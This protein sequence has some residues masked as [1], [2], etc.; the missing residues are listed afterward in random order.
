MNLKLARMASLVFA[1]GFFISCT[2]TGVLVSDK[3]EQTDTQTLRSSAQQL[4]DDNPYSPSGNHIAG[5]VA[6]REATE[7]E[8]SERGEFYSEMATRFE[9][10]LA[11]LRDNNAIEHIIDTKTRA[12]DYE[13]RLAEQLYE[14]DTSS[15]QALTHARNASVIQ[16]DSLQA[17]VLSSQILIAQGD[18]TEASEYL[19]HAV[20]NGEPAQL[21]HHFETFA[22]LKTRQGDYELAANWYQRSINWLIE[23]DGQ[24][25]QPTGN[26]ISR[27]SLL[28]AYHGAINTLSEA[29]QSNQA[30]FYLEHLSAVIENNNIYLE[31]LIVQ[32]FNL[33]RSTALDAYGSINA[34]TLDEN[35]LR[36]RRTVDA[37]PSAILFTAAEFVDLASGHIDLQSQVNPDFIPLEDPTVN[38]LLEEARHLF[39]RHL[40]TDPVSEEAIYGMASTFTLTGNDAEA[41]NWLEMLD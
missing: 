19:Q 12:W 23:Y 24:T 30:I 2:G 10:A 26:D 31:M 5:I 37:N 41:D 28:N 22:F 29:G 34:E 15:M 8:P 21:G 33:I 9:T 35:I 13:F 16:P 3:I 40:Q 14:E 32:Y 7:Q 4:L 18:L 25:L 11:G 27:G 1:F 38:V 17:F 6:Y 39:E 36:I 20:Q